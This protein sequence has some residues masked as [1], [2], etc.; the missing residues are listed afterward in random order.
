MFHKP[1]LSSIVFFVLALLVSTFSVLWF[2]P[3][4]IS[5]D[6]FGYYL[7]LPA[8][9]IY[10]DL[11]LKDIDTIKGLWET[12]QSSGTFYQ[13]FALPNG[14]WVMKYSAGMAVL[15]LP[16]FIIGHI[17]A[18]VCSYPADGFSLPYQIG[19]VTEMIAVL[20]LGLYLLRKVLLHFFTETVTAVTLVCVVLGTNYFIGNML[21]GGGVQTHGYLFTLY[22]AI[23]L[24]TI[25]WHQTQSIKNTVGLA[26]MCGLT[27]LSRPSEI[28]CLFIPLLW[29][30]TSIDT[31]KQKAKLL[32]TNWKNLLLFA[33][34]LAAIGSIQLLYWKSV[35]GSF[36]YYSYGGSSGEAF[37]FGNPHVLDVLFSYRK[38]WFVYTPMMFLASVGLFIAWKRKMAG[39]LGLLAF[40]ILNFWIISS[41][42]CWWYSESYGQRSL[43]QSYPV[44]ALGLG[45]VLSTDKKWLQRLMFG[46]AALLITLSVFQSYQFKSGVID[47]S[48]Q[49]KQ[50]YWASFWDTGPDPNLEHLKLVDRGTWGPPVMK[51]ESEYNLMVPSAYDFEDGNGVSR[52]LSDSMFFKTGKFSGYF[53][54]EFSAEHLV[55]FS[56]LTGGHYVWIRVSAWVYPKL[57][58]SEHPFSIAISAYHNGFGYSH[59]SLDSERLEDIKE[60]KWNRVVLEYLSPEMRAPQDDIK[61]FIWNRGGNQLFVDDYKMEVFVPKFDPVRD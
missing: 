21:V 5:W 60:G 58:V 40:V 15:Y 14:N 52:M 19:M 26:V 41:W 17:G 56:T 44:M 27:I 47:A 49:T 61:A 3:N 13:A 36:Y 31:V 29:G 35:T 55:K 45:F 2:P 9:F 34:I 23:L 25:R 42:H 24:L 46:L 33:V 6:V 38:G 54:D 32:L 43:I 39:T 37:S 11:G 4:I 28:V 20:V 7:Y 51:N 22:A 57:S 53:D 59:E 8:A 10:H 50:Y 48:R 1:S 18:L 30:I 12:Y 16:A